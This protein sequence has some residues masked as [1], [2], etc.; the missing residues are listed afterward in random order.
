[1]INQNLSLKKGREQIPSKTLCYKKS[2]VTSVMY[3]PYHGIYDTEEGY[4]KCRDTKKYVNKFNTRWQVRSDSNILCY[5]INVIKIT[6]YVI[7]TKGF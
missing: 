2:I 4:R 6:F 7:S 5:V 1:M 3:I